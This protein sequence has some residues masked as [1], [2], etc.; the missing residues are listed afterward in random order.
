MRQGG[1]QLFFGLQPG[2]LEVLANV[3]LQEAE[4]AHPGEED[5]PRRDAVRNAVTECAK[6]EYS[7]TTE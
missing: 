7:F 3:E 2:Q 1:V 4:S 5:K 6:H